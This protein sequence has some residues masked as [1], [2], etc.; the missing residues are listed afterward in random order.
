MKT[1][2]RPH[3]YGLWEMA[4]RGKFVYLYFDMG[5]KMKIKLTEDMRTHFRKADWDYFEELARQKSI[6]NTEFNP[7]SCEVM[8]LAYPMSAKKKKK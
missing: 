3:S 8:S 1:H 4:R 7:T 6:D 2:T 5:P